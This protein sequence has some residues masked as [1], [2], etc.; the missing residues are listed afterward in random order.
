MVEEEEMKPIINED[1]NTAQLE[2]A[3]IL[4]RWADAD[5]SLEGVLHEQQREAFDRS[6]LRVIDGGRNETNT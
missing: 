4:G 6:G 3:K 2:L 5:P 1:V